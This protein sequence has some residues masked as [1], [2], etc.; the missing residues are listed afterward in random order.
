[1]LAR[2]SN[3]HQAQPRDRG[4]GLMDN[5]HAQLVDCKVTKGVCSGVRDGAN[6][7]DQKRA[8]NLD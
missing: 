2:M 7:P 4:D 6:A 1:M 3:D 5:R 8:E